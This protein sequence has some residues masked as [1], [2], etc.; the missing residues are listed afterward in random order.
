MNLNLPSLVDLTPVMAVFATLA[1]SM[2]STTNVLQWL[3]NVLLD[4]L[5]AGMADAQRNDILRG[6]LFVMNYAV[7]LGIA[8]F[9][10]FALSP[11]L[12]LAV[13]VGAVGATVGAHLSYGYTQKT[14]ATPPQPDEIPVGGPGIPPSLPPTDTPAAAALDVAA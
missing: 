10:H 2:F 12:L 11:N 9:F 14:P 7:I 3:R 5:T 1:G 6:I 8:L 13:L 4:R